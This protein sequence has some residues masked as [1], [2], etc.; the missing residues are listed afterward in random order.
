MCYSETNFQVLPSAASLSMIIQHPW[1]IRFLQLRLVNGKCHSFFEIGKVNQHLPLI[2]LVQ[3]GIWKIG[4]LTKKWATHKNVLQLLCLETI[5][6]QHSPF[7]HCAQYKLFPTIFQVQWNHYFSW[8]SVL[9]IKTV[10]VGWFHIFLSHHFF[11]PFVCL[12]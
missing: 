1:N 10:S 6:I 9:Q 12:I 2:P 4:L 3:R 7:L 11:L 8:F 5:C